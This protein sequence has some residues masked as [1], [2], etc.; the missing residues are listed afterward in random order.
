MWKDSIH[1]GT[2]CDDSECMTGHTGFGRPMSQDQSFLT[3]LTLMGMGTGNIDPVDVTASI[4]YHMLA[5]GKDEKVKES[6]VKI[7][8]ELDKLEKRI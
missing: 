7:R 8:E 4:L 2:E 3:M 5:E 1:K 6:I